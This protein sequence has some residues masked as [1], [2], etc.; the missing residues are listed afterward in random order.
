MHINDRFKIPWTEMGNTKNKNKPKTRK[1]PKRKSALN[2]RLGGR[3]GTSQSQHEVISDPDS[4]LD[5]DETSSDHEWQA[6]AGQ[7][8]RIFGRNKRSMFFMSLEVLQCILNGTTCRECNNGVIQVDITSYNIF[9]AN[10][11]LQCDFC[12]KEKSQWSGPDNLNKAVFMAGKFTG[13]KKGQLGNFTKCLNFG[14]VGQNGKKWTVNVRKDHAVELNR[15]LDISLDKMKIEDQKGI[16]EEVKAASDKSMV[17]LACDG[18][19][20]IRK[21][22]GVCVSTAMVSVNGTSKVLGE[23]FYEKE[24]FFIIFFKIHKFF[25]EECF[26]KKECFL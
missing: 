2:G 21:N 6:P 25:S 13:I 15:Q 18:Y 7:S 11:L 24:C 14:F 19:Y 26:S 5:C 4:D 10:L 20:P 16:L 17:K 22:S 8:T 12:K 3:P 23:C 9:N 1:K